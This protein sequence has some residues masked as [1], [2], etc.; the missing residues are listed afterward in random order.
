MD[1]ECMRNGLSSATT[2]RSTCRQVE[3]HWVTVCIRTSLGPPEA[4]FVAKAMVTAL[5]FRDPQVGSKVYILMI[6][7]HPVP[8]A[9]PL[10]GLSASRYSSYLP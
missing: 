5:E 6:K 10:K 7:V 2:L 9:T 1:E 3:R 8:G 4:Y